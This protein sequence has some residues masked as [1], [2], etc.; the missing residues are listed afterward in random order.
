MNNLLYKSC[1]RLKNFRG[2]RV[3]YS[4]FGTVSSL[5]GEPFAQVNI[6]A[7]ASETCSHHQEEATTENN[8]KYRLRGLN[9]GCVYTV[10]VK[11]AGVDGS[12]VER[13]LPETR[14]VEVGQ[15]DVQNVN[16]IAISPINFSDV[17][18]RVTAATNDLY[19]T[20]RLV[21]YR[22]G[23]YDSPIYSQRVESPLN[24]KAR[25]NPGILVLLPRIPL[26]GKTY[27][28]EL[29]S[30]LSDKTYTYTVPTKQF[31]ADRI[32]IY[33]ELDFTPEVKSYEADL[34]QNSIS[35]LILVALVSIAFFKQDI[36][37]SF[38]DFVWSKIS[39]IADDFAQKQ[40]NQAK[41]TVRKVEPI[42]QKEIEQMA[43]QINN[44]KKKKTK[45][46]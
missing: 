7:T 1:F 27:V 19:K 32:S 20:L 12:N 24:P 40:K 22:K 30:S 31:V 25:Y 37:V 2:K 42:N 34:N 46:I 45:K 8:G 29:R 21:V 10:R 9:P 18:V 6:E 38:L 15:E 11:D 17:A 5:N 14:I 28:V 33:L 26:D 3:A 23:S 35:A 13:S 36:A 44:I 16:F 43:E 4:V 41:N 39:A